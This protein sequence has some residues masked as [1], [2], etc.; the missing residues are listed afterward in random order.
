[1]AEQIPNNTPTPMNAPALGPADA[2]VA[3]AAVSSTYAGEIVARAGTYY[4]VTRFLMTLLF[5]GFGIA[6]IKDGFFK[7]P[8]ENSQAINKGQAEPHPGLDVPLNQALGILLPPLGL[9]TLGWT[10]FNSRGAYRLVNDTLRVPG[11]N[12]IQ[13]NAIRKIDKR[14]WDRKGIAYIEYEIAGEPEPEQFKLDDFV[15]QRD[16]TD[17]ILERLEDHVRQQ[18]PAA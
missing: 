14:L 15:Y 9:F 12:P 13:L 17:Q 16:P 6:C 18:H 8:R 5:L 4:R 7:Y 10:L 2:A 1:M 11:H 3:S